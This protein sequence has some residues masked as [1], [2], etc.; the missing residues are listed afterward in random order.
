[1]RAV[2]ISPPGSAHL[3]I[4][5]LRPQAGDHDLRHRTAYLQALVA[6][7]E[8]DGT[9][10]VPASGS[11]QS[12]E[13]ASASLLRSIEVDIAKRAVTA[14]LVIGLN[15]NPLIDTLTILGSALELQLHVLTRLGKR[16]LRRYRQ[17]EADANKAIGSGIADLR[18]HLKQP[19]SPPKR[20]RATK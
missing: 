5:P 14:G 20:R 7:P 4:H 15:R 16:V 10:L 1:L 6:V 2:W 17:M 18:R 12:Y 9:A 19:A 11:R 13:D 3:Q 8:W